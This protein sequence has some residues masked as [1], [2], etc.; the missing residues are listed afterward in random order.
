MMDGRASAPSALRIWQLTHRA[1][2]GIRACTFAPVKLDLVTKI[3]AQ[4]GS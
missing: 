3:G 2:R 1:S 4:T